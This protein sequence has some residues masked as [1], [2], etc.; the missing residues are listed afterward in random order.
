MAAVESVVVAGFAVYRGREVF[1]GLAERMVE[2]TGLRVRLYLDI[3]REHG[4]LSE[5]AD[6][7]KQFARK[8]VDQDWPH[9]FPF[10]EV[11]YD[12]RSFK[13]EQAKQSRLHAKCVVVD[14][15]LA[16]VTS[17]NFTEAA[18]ERNIEAGVMVRSPRFAAR[19]ADH[20]GVLADA[21]QLLKLDLPGCGR[22][23]GGWTVARFPD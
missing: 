15:Q 8:F 3:H 12:P 13:H 1:R 4:D 7:V 22:A 11:F 14:R 16:F 17:A 5:D 6:I 19:L 18:Q 21:G 2:Q 20:F 23:P 9:G 10:P